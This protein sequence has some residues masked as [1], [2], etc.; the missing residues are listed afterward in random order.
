M[1]RFRISTYLMC[2][3]IFPASI[4][5]LSYPGNDIFER[6]ST[7]SC[8]SGS[9]QCSGLPSGFCCPSSDNCMAVASNTTVVC[10]SKGSDCTRIQPIGCDIS[11]LDVTKHPEST[12]LTTNLN[13]T[14]PI[15][16]NTCCPFGFSCTSGGYCQLD[17]SQGSTAPQTSSPT[18]TSTPLPI[19]SS[20]SATSSCPSAP[21]CSAAVQPAC[22]NF[23][24]P[25][26][27]AGFFPGMFAGA[28]LAIAGFCLLG[29]HRRKQARLS[30]SF[31]KVSA[32]IS[33]PIYQEG[34]AIRT[35]FIRKQYSAPSTPTRQPTIQRVRSL[36]RKSAAATGTEMAM[37]S[38]PGAPALPNGESRRA[39][40]TPKLQREPSG[41]SIN[42][43][44]D[45]STARE[46]SRGGGRES[47][48]TTFTD[49]MDRADQN[50]GRNGAPS[51][52]RPSPNSYNT[53]PRGLNISRYD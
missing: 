41:E 35:D 23:P 31:G 21:N 22:N 14:L 37:T 38:S 7:P 6:Q 53:M 33:D 2:A 10:C 4:I 1:A 36:F 17:T 51:L 13:K 43:F 9:L 20:S 8:A 26:I 18:G 11:Q 32:S 19:S 45:P 44:A 24:A 40:V 42:I 3:A 30:G 52:P 49:M 12:I 27:F 15:C 47:Q 34:S 28:A 50:K 39:P 16:G 25:A 48:Q 5:A 46:G 29:A